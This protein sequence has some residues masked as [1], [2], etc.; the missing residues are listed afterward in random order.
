MQAQMTEAKSKY[1]SKL[2]NDFAFSNNS[3]IYSYLKSSSKN[4]DFPPMLSLESEYAGTS[5]S[6]D[7]L[8]N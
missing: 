8:F 2:V 6:K 7:A 3:K 1:E 4:D 5:P